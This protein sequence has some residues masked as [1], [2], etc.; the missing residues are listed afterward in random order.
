[1]GALNKAVNYADSKGALVVSSAGND[2][3]DLDKDRNRTFV[4]CQS[5]TSFCVG[6]TTNLDLLVTYS[7]HGLSGPQLTAP[8]GGAPSAP[9]P[10]ASGIWGPCSAH[11]IWAPV[12]ATGNWYLL[13]TGTSMAAPHVAGAAA[14]AD[15]VAAGGPGSAGAGELKTKLQR[16]ADDLGRPGADNVYS[17]GRLNTLGAVQ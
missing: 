12:C 8:G 4:P 9:S 16:T 13:G 3:V 14:L 15:S 17:H 5:G 6:A 11:S 2:A 7:N 10:F 1:M